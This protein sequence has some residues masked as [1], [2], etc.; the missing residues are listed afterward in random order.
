MRLGP[1]S[2]STLPFKHS[3]NQCRCTYR[4][5]ARARPCSSPRTALSLA[6]RGLRSLGQTRI[7]QLLLFSFFLS[8][9]RKNNRCKLL[10]F[11]GPLKSAFTLRS[12][13]FVPMIINWPPP[14]MSA[15]RLPRAARSHAQLFP[16]AVCRCSMAWTG[17]R[18]MGAL[19]VL[20]ASTTSTWASPRSSH[21]T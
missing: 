4:R 8:W 17:H 9:S 6:H 10:D 5:C 20:L 1:N 2:T 14:D 11:A 12:A 18:P 7:S 16:R 19:S 21:P 15:F 13:D 3:R